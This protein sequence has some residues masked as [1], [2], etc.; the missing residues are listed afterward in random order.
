[1]S[2]G[3]TS[4]E[5]AEKVVL[6]WE[7]RGTTEPEE[8]PKTLSE[9]FDELFLD[10]DRRGLSAAT[11][12][13]YR[14]V[15]RRL[16]AYAGASKIQFVD[17]LTVS[18]I[19]QFCA[20]LPH[21]G[22]SAVKELERLKSVFRFF[23][24]NG[25]IRRNPATPLRNPVVEQRPTMP[26]EPDEVDRIYEACK[27]Y[28][29]NYGQTEQ[30]NAVRLRAFVLVLRYTGLRISDVVGLRRDQVEEDCVF[31]YTAKTGVPVRVPIPD[32]VVAALE[33]APRTSKDHYFWTGTSKKK[34][35]VGDWQRSLRKLFPLAGVEGGHAH[36]FRDTFAVELL[37]RGVPLERVSKLL[38]HRSVKITE[39]HY[40]PWVGQLQQQL[41]ADVRK[42]WGDPLSKRLTAGTPEVHGN[43][44]FVN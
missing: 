38:G 39:K 34:S 22:I 6:E 18:D 33:M 44:T 13:K 32:F 10:A 14:L 7:F 9:A 15:R 3:T 12:E 27:L 1:M 24:E 43:P 23:H 26:F 31:L 4:W 30:D 25:W 5:R 20:G 8:P 28:T 2:I 36:R 29:D 41:E 19:R 21:N 16:E 40:A 11:L 35:A 17:E 37:K 42:T